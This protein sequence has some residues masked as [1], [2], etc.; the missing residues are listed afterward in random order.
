MLLSF[1]SV[2]FRSLFVFQIGVEHYDSIGDRAQSRFY[3]DKIQML[4]QKPQILKYLGATQKNPKQLSV[5]S[6]CL[7]SA[8]KR[9]VSLSPLISLQARSASR[10][11]SNELSEIA[12][13]FSGVEN[14][15][16]DSLLDQFEKSK[17]ISE[18]VVMT[19]LLTQSDNIKKRLAQRSKSRQ[20]LGMRS[21]SSQN[22]H[23]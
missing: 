9:H 21:K 4:L 14:S 16:T 6:S 5:P 20:A 2:T 1:Y 17:A 7:S 11:N 12:S 19:D 23:G 22:F 8:Q 18:H 10:L 3:R 13:P 15:K